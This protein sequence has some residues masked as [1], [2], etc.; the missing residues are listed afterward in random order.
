MQMKKRPML[1]ADG[2]GDVS[3]SCYLV[4]ALEPSSLES[5]AIT[6]V[7]VFLVGS[8]LCQR[9]TVEHSCGFMRSG[10]TWV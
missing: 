7:W 3:V 5:F 4:E 2:D 10:G 9:G 1:L 8:T 6:F